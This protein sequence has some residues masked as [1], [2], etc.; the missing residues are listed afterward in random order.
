VLDSKRKVHVVY[1]TDEAIKDSLRARGFKDSQIAP[2]IVRI[3]RRALA[4][5]IERPKKNRH[6]L[7]GDYN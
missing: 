3:E 2:E 1:L 4:A 5:D 6:L 7:E